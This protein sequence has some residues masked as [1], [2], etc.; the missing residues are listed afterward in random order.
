VERGDFV[1]IAYRL[2]RQAASGILSI[3]CG[4]PRPE[5]IVLRRGAMVIGDGELARRAAIA[6]LA[7]LAALDHATLAFHGGVAASPPGVQPRLELAEWARRH[8]EAQLDGTLA[9]LLAR[10]L[11]GVRLCVRAEL[12][13]TPLDDADRR[14]LAAMA[15]PRRLDQIW[16]LA[17]TPRFRLLAFVYF[18]RGVGALDTE[19][20]VAEQSGRAIDERRRAACKLLGIADDA[21][22]DAVKRAYRRLARALHPDLQPDVDAGQRR[23]LEQ[24][25]A[26]VTAAYESVTARAH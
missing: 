19:G 21:D 11:A 13:P 5:T 23:A 15:R 17:R 14:M 2:G 20:V 18:L 4:S 25:F 22:L 12:A 9:E 8:L 6:R 10:E 7:R 3:D 1:R 16:P 24:R 26:E